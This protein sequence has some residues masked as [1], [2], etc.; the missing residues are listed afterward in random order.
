MDNTSDTFSVKISMRIVE[1]QREKRAV[2]R[3][4]WN[5]GIILKISN[6]L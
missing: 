1:T 4:L 6:I 5:K 2:L 3:F